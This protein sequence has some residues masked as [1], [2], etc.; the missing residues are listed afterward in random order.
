V[1]AV[2]DLRAQAPEAVVAVIGDPSLKWALPEPEREAVESDIVTGQLVFAPAGCNGGHRAFMARVA[3]RAR[4]KGLDPIAVTDQV[5]PD[6]R[7]AR[8]RRD[9]PRWVFDLEGASTPAVTAVHTAANGGRR[10]RR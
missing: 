6:C 4:Q 2:S 10:R 5:I 1:A 9:G 8:V 7:I 3:E